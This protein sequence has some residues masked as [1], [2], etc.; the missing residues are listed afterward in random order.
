MSDSLFELNH[1]TYHS[2][3]WADVDVD[4]LKF[5]L[6]QIQ[7]VLSSSTKVMAVV[8]ADAY[9]H[10]DIR[11]A[12]IML[13]NGVDFLAVSN[14]DEALSLR[15]SDFLDQSSYELLILGYTPVEFAAVLYEFNITQTI[16]SYEYGELL[17]RECEKLNINVKA[18]IKVDTGMSRV[19][20]NFDSIEEISSLYKLENIDVCGIFTHLSSAD[21]GDDSSVEFTLGQQRKFDE[22]IDRLSTSSSN[23]NSIGVTHIQNSAGVLTLN[24]AYDYARVGL[25]LYGINP[26]GSHGCATSI[27]LKPVM[28]LKSVVAM[29]KEVDKDTAVSYGRHY[30]ATKSTK[31][32]TIP[33]GYADGYS[34]GLSNKGCVLIKGEFAPILGRVCMDQIMVD[35][36]DIDVSMGDIV[37]LV[38]SEGGNTI[39]FDD[40]S[41]LVGTIPYELLCLI[42]K[43]VPRETTN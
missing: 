27:D 5:N 8:K 33:I 16:I 12:R 26:I 37:T 25:M 29:V 18:H 32:A 43:R 21:G 41:K 10:G 6:T 20:V 1:L 9:G 38:G 39:L 28:S 15:N 24:R 35:V 30:V 3:A 42:G 36:T 4:N 11:V 7:N 40:I 34:R 22:C 17:H 31:I 23:I 2:R 13:D 19:G 14:I